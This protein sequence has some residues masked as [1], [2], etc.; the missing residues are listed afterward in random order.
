MDK[1]PARYKRLGENHPTMIKLGKLFDLAEELGI[2]IS[3]NSNGPA[4]IYDKDFVDGCTPLSLSDIESPDY[5]MDSFPCTLE[6]KVTF[7]NPEYIQYLEDVRLAQEAEAEK[8]RIEAEKHI[9]ELKARGAEKR[10]KAKKD[11]RAKRVLSLQAR[12]QKDQ[13]E[14]QRLQQLTE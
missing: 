11:R 7:Q 13:L 4:H 1:V 12:L 8:K 5:P 9:A 14:L 3:Y 6:Y 10:A 2:S